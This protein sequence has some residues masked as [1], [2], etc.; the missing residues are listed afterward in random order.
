MKR[1]FDIFFSAF[2]LILLS[3]LL[4]LIA[5]LVWIF[6]GRPVFFVQMRPGLGEKPFS[7]VKF[8]TMTNEKDS[9]G[10]YLPNNLRETKFGNFLRKTSLDEL[11]E[12][13]NVLKGDMSIVGPRPL[14][15][16]YLSLYNDQ[17]RKRHKL[18]PGITGWSQINGRNGVSWSERFEHDIWYIDHCSFRLDIKIL[19]R[20]LG[21]VLSRDGTIL[22]EGTTMT[23]FKGNTKILILG[24]GWDQL[25][26]IQKS[27]DRGYDTILVDGDENC[28]GR[29]YSDDF[30]KIGT[31]DYKKIYELASALDVDAI[32]YMITESPIY[33]AYYSGLRLNL[34]HPS[35]KSVDA[36]FSK[37][38]MREILSK[39][40]VPDIKFF[41]ASNLGEAIVA[42][43]NLSFPFV[44][45]SADVGGQLGLFFVEK[46]TSPVTIIITKQTII[47]SCCSLLSTL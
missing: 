19:W 2:L 4:I 34:P 23:R 10:F 33:S 7:M 43:K 36:T 38:K 35:R 32:S 45:K 44:M 26:I 24:G 40:G 1:L 8:R 16:E 15:M 27:K 20:T 42:A 30:Y 5:M 13:W 41:K 28:I 6:I 37:I 22:E 17:Q 46:Y 29:S 21:K 11:P 3:P 12:F 47:I 14:L 39:S 9:S 25:P 31:R 18:K